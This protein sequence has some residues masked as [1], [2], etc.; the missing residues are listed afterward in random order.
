MTAN[1]FRLFLFLLEDF[2]PCKQSGFT[3][4]AGLG[5]AIS[6]VDYTR[7]WQAVQENSTFFLIPLLRQKRSQ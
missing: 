2:F 4:L 1:N 6:E 5:Y 3:P 7:T